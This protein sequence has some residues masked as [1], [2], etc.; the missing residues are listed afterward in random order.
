MNFSCYVENKSQSIGNIGKFL[1]KSL[2]ES[3]QE[4]NESIEKVND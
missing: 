1:V 3:I 4:M 2:S